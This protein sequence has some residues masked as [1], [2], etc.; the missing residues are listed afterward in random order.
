[1]AATTTPRDERRC[2]ASDQSGREHISGEKDARPVTTVRIPS[3][4]NDVGRDGEAEEKADR[5]DN[6]RRNRDFDAF[7]FGRSLGSEG[8]LPRTGWRT[9][10]PRGSM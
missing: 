2:E 8:A 5:S 10:R 6:Q 4:F 3:I 7:H 9:R 1:M